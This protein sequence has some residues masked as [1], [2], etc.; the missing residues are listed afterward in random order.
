MSRKRR[1]SKPALFLAEWGLSL[2]I[3]LA[4]LL[5]RWLLWDPVTVSGHS[6][7]PTLQDKEHLIMVKTTSIDR[8]DIVV[9][10][11]VGEDGKEIQI[12]KR[13]IGMPGD[14][15]RF[16]NDVLYINEEQVDEPYLAEYLAAFQK[17]RL[18]EVYSYDQRFQA[19]AQTAA[20]FTT[21]ANGYPDFTIKVPEGQYLLLGDDRLVSRD[22]R[23]TG[24]VEREDITGEVKLR[25][26]PLNRLGS[27]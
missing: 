2:L 9:A 15:I 14:M 6:M 19:L 21:D 10:N 8:F 7:D 18:Q 22:G 5:S 13:V 24:P 4:I 17:D 20:A 12:V 25:M 26:W 3:I 1:Q 23:R 27:F 16:E 11:E